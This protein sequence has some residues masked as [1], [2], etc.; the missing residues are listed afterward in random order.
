MK[1]QKPSVVKRTE[2][3]EFKIATLVKSVE[4]WIH[5]RALKFSRRINDASFDVEDLVSEGRIGALVAAHRF[6]SGRGFK[7]L[8]YASYWIDQHIRRYIENHNALIRVPVHLRQ[9]RKIDDENTF[10]GSNN[11]IRLTRSGG[12][13]SIDALAD[14]EKYLHEVIGDETPSA[15]DLLTESEGVVR[16]LNRL[17]ERERIVIKQRF[18]ND[19]TLKEIGAK[20]LNLTSE[21]VRQIEEV[22]L[23]KLHTLF[24][25]PT[26][27]LVTSKP[28]S[29]LLVQ[30]ALASVSVETLCAAGWVKGVMWIDPLFKRTYTLDKAREIHAGRVLWIIGILTDGKHPPRKVKPVMTNAKNCVVGRPRKVL[31]DAELATAR[32]MKAGGAGWRKIALAVSGMRGESVSHMHIKRSLHV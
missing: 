23:K 29:P 12:V 31:T 2:Q 14:G 27:P 11:K 30:I 13:Q 21:R 16:F 22:A 1:K 18:W 8:T 7:F 9:T 32:A 24:I 26:K 15:E 19:A 6:D 25:T 20:Q 4:P 10:K 17:S 3:T 28:K 5:K